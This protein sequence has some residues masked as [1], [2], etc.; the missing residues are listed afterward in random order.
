MSRWLWYLCKLGIPACI[1]R[2]SLDY[3][4]L[5]KE[6]P[7]PSSVNHIYKTSRPM[8]KHTHSLS[9]V[10][11]RAEFITNY[12]WAQSTVIDH[13]NETKWTFPPLHL[14]NVNTVTMGSMINTRYNQIAHDTSTWFCI[15]LQH[16]TINPNPHS[17]WGIS[18][19]PSLTFTQRKI[20]VFNQSPTFSGL[21]V[22]YN[23]TDSV[24]KSCKRVSTVI[25]FSSISVSVLNQRFVPMTII[26]FIFGCLL[27]LSISFHSHE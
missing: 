23:R 6:A 2:C 17:G 22:I 4:L 24:L 21:S 7:G 3:E 5:N 11:S 27:C 10:P 16:I 13:S 19:S 8:R 15:E 26:I 9:S 1:C 18:S 20:S 12:L 14:H 25:S